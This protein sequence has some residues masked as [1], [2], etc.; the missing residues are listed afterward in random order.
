MECIDLTKKIY[1]LRAFETLTPIYCKTNHDDT[2]TPAATP[3]SRDRTKVISL[4]A[5]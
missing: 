4:G 3:C 5:L 2:A 1:R